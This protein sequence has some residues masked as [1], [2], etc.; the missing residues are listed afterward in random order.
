VDFS[1]LE[2]VLVLLAPTPVWTPATTARDD[3]VT[4]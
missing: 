2:T 3:Q 4:R 1:T